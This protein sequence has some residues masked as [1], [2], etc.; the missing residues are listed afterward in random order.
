[1]TAKEAYLRLHLA[2]LLA[3]G[4]GLFGRLISLS[5][6]P[7]V[8]YRVVI[9]GLLL[10]LI[11]KYTGKIPTLARKDT[12]QIGL[13]G[14]LLAVHWV[15]FYG[16]IK[17]SNV[18]VGVV[19]F[20]TV[21]FYTAILEP[22]INRHKPSWREIGLSLLTLAGIL[23]IFQLDARYRFGILLGMVSAI[24]YALFSIFSKK[25]QHSTGQNSSTMLLYELLGG[26]IVLSAVLPAYIYFF[27][28]LP[29]IPTGNDI[30]FLLLFCSVFTVGLFLL[31]FQALSQISAF[32]VNLSYNLEPVYSI[33]FAMILFGEARELGPSFWIGLSLII[34]SVGIQ[35]FF[36]IKQNT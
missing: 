12:L 5:E 21:G 15:F 32:T 3:G 19:C 35:A 27:P 7:Q 4:T 30:W 33:I 8:W 11:L 18:S 13:C 24:L 31:H 34:L 20:A 25:V 10:A 17:A 14:A 6:V 1:M 23:L 36:S 22:L 28:N 29:F 26:G 9:A 2:I 16:S